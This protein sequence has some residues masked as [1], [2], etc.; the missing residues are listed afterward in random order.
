M[1]EDLSKLN[2]VLDFNL[3][4]PTALEDLRISVIPL[5]SETSSTPGVSKVTIRSFAAGLGGQLLV[6]ERAITLQKLPMN[7]VMTMMVDVLEYDHPIETSIWINGLGDVVEKEIIPIRAGPQDFDYEI[8]TASHVGVGRVQ[9]YIIY[10]TRGV[11][12]RAL[13]WTKI[14]ADK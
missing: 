8:D 10:T 1:L 11:R 6:A 12:V 2:I 5:L 13:P 7:I 14:P 4:E 3:A 9:P